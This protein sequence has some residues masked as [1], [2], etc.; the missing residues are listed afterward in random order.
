[1][2]LTIPS[3]ERVLFRKS[4][5]RQVI[6]QLRFPPVLSIAQ[7]VPIALQEALRDEYPMFAEQPEVTIGLRPS[8]FAPV[9]GAST[10]AWRFSDAEENWSVALAATFLAMDTSRSE[11]FE[12]FR[13]R[14]RR[15][16]ERAFDIHRVPFLT[17][18]G[19]RYLNVL[20]KPSDAD[21]RTYGP[22]RITPALVGYLS[23]EL[24]GGGILSS[25]QEI[26]LPE[27]GFRVAIRCGLDEEGNLLLDMD[28]FC[29]ERTEVIAVDTLLARFNDSSYRL[30]RWCVT[31][32]LFQE[33]GPYTEAND[34]H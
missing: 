25:R 5:L 27:A 34:G 4:P 7:E 18:V 12:D 23:S 20:E 16:W 1:M 15:V 21:P 8:S 6:C 28:A 13:R 32:K 14:F 26:H 2:A 19:L 29:Q 17:R 9:A 11:H 33:M 3:V 24:A 22:E 31:S 10:R 30:F